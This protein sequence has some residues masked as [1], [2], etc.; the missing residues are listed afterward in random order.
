MTASEV[1][2]AAHAVQWSELQNTGGYPGVI[3]GH[4]SYFFSWPSA[5]ML[6]GFYGQ[7]V[8]AKQ[9]AGAAEIYSVNL[10]PI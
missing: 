10:P 2:D 9:P 8:N 1:S 4:S 6:Q 3:G 5:E 7:V